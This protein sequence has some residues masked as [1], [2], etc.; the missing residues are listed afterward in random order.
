[1]FGSGFGHHMLC[2]EPAPARPC[3]FY[4]FG[5]STDYSFDSDFANSTGCIGFAADPTITHRSKLHPN[6]YFAQIAA[7]SY[8][9][10]DTA[11]FPL[12]ASVP[13]IRALFDHDRLAVLKMD[14]EGCEYSLARDILAEDP[15]FFKRVDNFVVEVHYSKVLMKSKAHLYSYAALIQLLEDAGL[16]LIHFEQ[17]GCGP[18]HQAQGFLSEL[19]SVTLVDSLHYLCHNYLFA[20]V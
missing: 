12:R 11:M 7:A 16:E 18:E 3:F 8:D 19:R 2:T 13:G 1:M 15:D 17:S 5:I 14:C 6:V 20:R 4:S 10:A 9:A